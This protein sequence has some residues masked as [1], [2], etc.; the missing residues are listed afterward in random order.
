MTPLSLHYIVEYP[1]NAVKYIIILHTTLRWLKQ[2]IEQS[3]TSQSTL[4]QV[5][6]T[7]ELWGVFVEDSVKIWPRYNG[8]ALYMSF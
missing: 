3:V 8:T 4:P 7:G 1:Y 5:G 2:N 6:L